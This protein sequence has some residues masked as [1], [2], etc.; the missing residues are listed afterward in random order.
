[1]P[2]RGVVIHV[3]CSIPIKLH[4]PAIASWMFTIRLVAQLYGSVSPDPVRRRTQYVE[5]VYCLQVDIHFVKGF[6]NVI[7][8][9]WH[10]ED[11]PWFS[12]CPLKAPITILLFLR[13]HIISDKK[14]TK[15][16]SRSSL[17]TPSPPRWH[18]QSNHH[19]HHHRHLLGQIKEFSVSSWY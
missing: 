7:I 18:H 5:S 14:N 10:T 11:K 9:P 6:V 16:N 1:M 13:N 8:G 12:R 3:I 17:V 19:H 15:G 4:R 2:V